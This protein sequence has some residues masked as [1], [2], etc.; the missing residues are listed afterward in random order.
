[1]EIDLLYL[2]RFVAYFFVLCAATIGL[3]VAY[4]RY[5]IWKKR[6]QL[7]EDELSARFLRQFNNSEIDQALAGYVVPH[8]SPSDPS[9]REGEEFLADT[10]ESIFFYVD[11]NIE[12]VERSFHLLLADTGMGKT[13]FCLN[14]YSHC[15]NKFPR[16]CLLIKPSRG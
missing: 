15:R 7:V 16:S 8:C 10:R 3:W 2:L 11:R 5:E 1:M 9:N 4:F 13:S 6:K 12:A 14:Y